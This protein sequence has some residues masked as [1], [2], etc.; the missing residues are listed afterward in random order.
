[1]FQQG[2]RKIMSFFKIEINLINI[3]ILFKQAIINILLKI[4]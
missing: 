2:V 4:N 1:M 3:I